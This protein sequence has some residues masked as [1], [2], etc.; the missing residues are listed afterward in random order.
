MV[1]SLCIKAQQYNEYNS[2]SALQVINRLPP[3]TN[4]VSRLFEWCLLLNRNTIPS[5]LLQYAKEA[6]EIAEKNNYKRGVGFSHY[7]N[8]Y[9]H[10]YSKQHYSIAITEIATAAQQFESIN[11]KINTGRSYYLA[12]NIYYDIGN[13]KDAVD[14]YITALQKWSSIGF[15]PLAGE[16]NNDLALAYARMGN[17]SKGVEYAYKGYQA[18]EAIADKKGMAQSLHLMGSLFYEFKNHENAMK[19]FVAASTIYLEVKDEFGFARNNNMIGEILLEQ[20]SSYKALEKFKQ[21]FTIYSSPNAPAWGIPWGYSNIG[22]VYEKQADA[23]ISEGLNKVATEK[24][25][26]ALNN[27]LLSLQKFEVLKDPA[28][29]AEQMI[30]IGKVYFKIDELSKAKKYLINGVNMAFKAGEKKH[31]ASSYFYLSKIDSANSNTSLAFE[32]YKKY[33]LYKDSVFNLQSSQNL[34][35]YKTQLDFEKKDHEISLLETENKLQ[36]ALSEKNTQGR[37]FAYVLATLFLVGSTYGYFRFKKQ[38][39]IKAEQKLLKERLAI[40]QD[41]HDSIGSTL[42][43]IAVY[44]QVA[45]IHG[46]NNEQE[47]MNELL[48]KISSASGETVTEMNDIVWALN[49]QNDSMEKILQRMESFAKPLTSARN[50]NF[51]F[52]YD[53]ALL[54]S[55]LGMNI[56]KNLYLIFKEAVN[57]CIKY[58]GAKRLTV[59]L[60]VKKQ[61]LELKVFDDGVG[62][63]VEKILE[64]KQSSLSGNGISNLYKRATEINGI[65]NIESN[66]GQGTLI[67]LH[68][69][70]TIS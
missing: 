33:V 51:S 36:K 40:S 35:L 25:A 61:L 31:L 2:D 18:S 16:C 27:Y 57:N 1:H 15:T 17:Y 22:S 29:I 14:N 65:L 5:N 50:I 68:L 37:N 53:N 59:D 45:K 26:K 64:N 13:Y 47:N 67:I 46:A 32:H 30:Y 58:S 34:L 38:S 69:P 6:K 3:D 66:L 10:Y 12:A 9:Y 43:S 54:Q 23:A 41:L 24:Y 56:R 20:D 19:N 8:A 55:S 4:K 48:E 21:S 7:I 44:S 63:N 52:T 39:K 49:P 42:S 28:G 11:D 60:H 62:F 70:L